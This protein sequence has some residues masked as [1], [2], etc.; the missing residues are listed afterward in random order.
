MI[1]DV[2]VS[3]GLTALIESIIQINKA[4]KCASLLMKMLLNLGLPGFRREPR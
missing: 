4:F 3:P 2:A 1:E